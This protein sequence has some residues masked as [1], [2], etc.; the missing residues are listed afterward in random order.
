MA[1]VNYDPVWCE[2]MGTDAFPC[3]WLLYKVNHKAAGGLDCS[4]HFWTKKEAD[5]QCDNIN[6]FGKYIW[7]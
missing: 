6:K 5:I 2:G 3:G 1:T 7:N 4:L